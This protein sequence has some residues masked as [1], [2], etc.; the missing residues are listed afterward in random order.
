MSDGFCRRIIQFHLSTNGDRFFKTTT[1]PD[2]DYC[3][4]EY[5]PCYINGDPP[6]YHNKPRYCSSKTFARKVKEKLGQYTVEE[7]QTI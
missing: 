5:V 1:N 7:K 4:V 2:S 3:E 6:K